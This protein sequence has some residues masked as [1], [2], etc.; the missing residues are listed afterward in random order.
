MEIEGQPLIV[1]L[2]FDFECN[3]RPYYE[4][5]KKDKELGK[6]FNLTID[7]DSCNLS[8]FM[9]RCHKLLNIRLR[10]SYLKTPIAK[11]EVLILSLIPEYIHNPIP[12]WLYIIKTDLKDDEEQI[13]D[14]I[15]KSIDWINSFP[16]IRT[17]IK[18]N[19]FYNNNDSKM[20]FIRP[21]DSKFFFCR[22]RTLN[23]LIDDLDFCM[24]LK[25]EDISE[26]A[27]IIIHCENIDEILLFFLNKFFLFDLS[28]ITK[29]NLDRLDE[30][31]DV[32]LK[33][34]EII[35]Q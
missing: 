14:K 13:R 34:K 18:C 22:G 28:D 10:A 21:R 20:D 23:K 19:K 30:C 6:Y 9:E 16:D 29:E 11:E 31:R 8:I 12:K 1:A 3:L 27:N 17:D 15:K 26:L 2:T 32:L 5:L 35:D 25:N 4:L 7:S 33:I 24:K